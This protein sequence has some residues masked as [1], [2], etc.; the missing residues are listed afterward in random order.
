M[1]LIN[2]AGVWA[3]GKGLFRWTYLFTVANA[4]VELILLMLYFAKIKCLL[5]ERRT[6]CQR[7]SVCCIVT[8][9]QEQGRISHQHIAGV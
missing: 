9:S 5:L 8:G 6:P 4:V 2:R 7:G 1:I 3:W